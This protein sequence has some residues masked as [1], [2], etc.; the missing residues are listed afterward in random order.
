MTQ[1][2]LEI[3]VCVLMVNIMILIVI[4]VWTVKLGVFNVHFSMFVQNVKL[5]EKGLAVTVFKDFMKMLQQIHANV[6]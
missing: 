2:K 1:V 6:N 3:N 5:I 4:N